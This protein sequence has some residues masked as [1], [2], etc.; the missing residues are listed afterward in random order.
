MAFHSSLS[1]LAYL[2]RP[3][4][5]LPPSVSVLRGDSGEAELRFLQ[6]LVVEYSNNSLQV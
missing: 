5:E 4:E 3:C 2:E 6:N 1:L